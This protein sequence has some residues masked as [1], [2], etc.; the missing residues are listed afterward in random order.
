MVE[1]AEKSSFHLAISVIQWLTGIDHERML[2][3]IG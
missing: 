2:F 1:N 3:M